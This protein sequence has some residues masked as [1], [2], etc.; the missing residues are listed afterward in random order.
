VKTVLVNGPRVGGGNGEG[1]VRARKTRVDLSGH[2]IWDGRGLARR[3]ILKEKL[4]KKEGREKENKE[5]Q[6]I[7]KKE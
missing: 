7:T 5:K 6:N 1:I 4:T 3:S 2:G